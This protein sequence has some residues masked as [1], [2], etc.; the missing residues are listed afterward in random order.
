MGA[1][2]AASDPRAFPKPA[3][4]PKIKVS[5]KTY[6]FTDAAEKVLEQFGNKQPM[7]YRQITEKARDFPLEREPVERGVLV[8][9]DLQHGTALDEL[10]LHSEEGIEVLVA[11]TKAGYLVVY[12]EK[13]SNKIVQVR[14]DGDQEI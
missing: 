3:P 13:L 2:P 5:G 11:P 6:S 1:K 7:H 4:K 8:G 10:A 12:S 14:A 9:P